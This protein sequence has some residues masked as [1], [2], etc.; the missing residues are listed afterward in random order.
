MRK[1]K[2]NGLKTKEQARV[3]LEEQ[4]VSIAE[5]ARKHD[6]PYPTVYQVLSGHKKGRRG[7]AHNAAV[8]LG[9]KRGTVLPPADA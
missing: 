5:F 7:Q 6:L 3:A 8:L 9:M 2:A 4:G 1:H